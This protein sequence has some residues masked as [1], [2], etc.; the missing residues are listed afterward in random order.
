MGTETRLSDSLQSQHKTTIRSRI[1]ALPWSDLQRSLWT[2]GYAATSALLTPEE[3]FEL[4]GLYA[5]DERFRSQVVMER[6][7]FGKGDYKYFAHPL[8]EVVREL[9][10]CAYPHLA[11][12]A[13]EWAAALGDPIRFPGEHAEFLERCHRAGQ[14]RPTPLLLH[15]EQDGYNC[16]HQDIYGAVAFPLQMVLMLGQQG[17]DW[18]GGEFVLV[19]QRPRAQSKAVVVS[20]DEGCAVIFT[21][22][23]RPVQGSKGCYRVNMKHG[24]ARVRS[25]RR[26]TLGII[27]H[28]AE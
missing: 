3:C 18:E 17:G 19:E 22:R 23:Y 5:H 16:L 24:V 14:K 10:T 26:Y 1:Q 28:D 6:L 21:T 20:V 2:S 4:R 7:R 13:N 12:V 15:Y 9:R 8:P 11:M 27:F 25:G